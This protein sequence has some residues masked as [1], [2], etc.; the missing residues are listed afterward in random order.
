V[1]HRHL[2]VTR[3]ALVVVIGTKIAIAST[4]QAV[5]I[6]EE[7]ITDPQENDTMLEFSVNVGKNQKPEVRDNVPDTVWLILVQVWKVVSNINM[8]IL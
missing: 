4:V 8:D 3:V 7:G 2:T 5:I 6:T 1:L